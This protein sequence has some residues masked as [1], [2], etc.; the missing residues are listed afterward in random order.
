M[1]VARVSGLVELPADFTCERGEQIELT[2]TM[3]MRTRTEDGT[4]MGEDK[5]IYAF[6]A[7]AVTVAAAAGVQ[8]PA[9]QIPPRIQLVAGTPAAIIPI[10]AKEA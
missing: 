1:N 4:A 5:W 10:R 6:K 7:D 8:A 9:P 2:F 3:T